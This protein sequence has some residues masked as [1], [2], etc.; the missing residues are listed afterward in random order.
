MGR[1][2]AWGLAFAAALGL[3]AAG[4]ALDEPVQTMMNAIL[5]CL[6]CLGVG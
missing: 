1:N 2:V 4:V 3:M 5:V 6:A